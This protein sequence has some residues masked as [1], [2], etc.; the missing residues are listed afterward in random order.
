MVSEKNQFGRLL[1]ILGITAFT[2]IG[3][4]W[5]PEKW[6]GVTIRK[7]DLLSDIR[8]KPERAAEDR[9][10]IDF[11]DADA[12]KVTDTL[13]VPENTVATVVR[14]DSIYRQVMATKAAR[15]SLPVA[16]EDF[17]VGRKGLA[18]FFAA[19]DSVDLMKRPVRVAFLGDSFIEGDILV[20]DFRAKMQARFGG[21]GVGFV[22]VASEVE[23]Y[24]PTVYQRSKGWQ[25]HSMLTDHKRRFTLSGLLFEPVADE[26]S[27]TFKTVNFYPRLQEVSSVKFLYTRNEASEMRL[28]CNGEKDT[29]TDILPATESVAQYETKGVFTDGKFR[30]R[31]VNGLQALGVALEDNEGIVVDNFSLRG[32]SGVTLGR[33]DVSSCIALSKIRSYDLIVLQYGL[34]VA[35]ETTRDYGWYCDE[36]TE[37]VRHVRQCFPETD[38]LLLGVSDRSYSHDGVFRTMPAVVS[39]LKA[40]R[41]VA[42]AAQVVFWNTFRAMG[43]ENS[44]LRYVKNN[45]ASKDYTHLSFRGGR[46]LANALYEALML[47]KELYNEMEQ[48]AD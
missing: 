33:L 23:Q 8:I 1:T 27:I 19:L 30:F 41:K 14:R 21:R 43:G 47:E 3:M 11:E 7:V 25:T 36:F 17:S 38:I 35:S 29:L 31:Q 4:Y 9:L 48:T 16:V 44:M 10:F 39:L 2:C 42:E 13:A 15:D 26:V 40:Q 28:I 46:E 6:M 12:P 5:L 24:R 18:H 34:N 45:W 20:A 37:V 22:P 32:N